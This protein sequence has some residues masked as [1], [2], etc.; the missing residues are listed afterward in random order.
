[1]IPQDVSVMISTKTYPV[2]ISLVHTRAIRAAVIRLIRVKYRLI[3]LSSMSMTRNFQ[4]AMTEQ[5]RMTRK[6]RAV[7]ASRT[8][9]RISFPQGAGNSPIVYVKAEPFFSV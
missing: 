8:P 7:S 2:K 1:M 5:K 4:P 6:K 3:L 9:A